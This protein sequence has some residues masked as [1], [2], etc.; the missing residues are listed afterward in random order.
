MQLCFLPIAMLNRSRHRR[1]V[2]A[3]GYGPCMTVPA[4]EYRAAGGHRAIRAS[5]REDID[6]ARLLQHEGHRVRFLRGADLAATRHYRSAGEVIRAWRRTYY[7]Y[8][9]N[10]LALA[11]FG[12]LGIAAVF[13][14][15]LALVPIAL[16]LGDRSAFAGALAGVAALAVL[17]VFVALNERQPLTTILWHPLTWLG[18]LAFQAFSV[19]DGLR[20]LPPRWRGRSLPLEAAQ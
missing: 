13:L 9:G 1:L 2:P 14:L 18:T 19:W 7:A 10:S 5:D 11:L 17:R 12:M 20:G 6:L 8:A 3:F 4:G 16:I 15:P